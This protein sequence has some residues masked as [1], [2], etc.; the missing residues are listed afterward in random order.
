MRRLLYL[1][2]LLGGLAIGSLYPLSLLADQQAIGNLRADNA[3]AGSKL[4]LSVIILDGSGNPVTSFGGTG[5]T[6]MTD[7][8]AF[9]VGVATITPVGGTYRSTLDTVNDGDAG[10]FA[11]L[12]NRIQMV[13][14]VDSSGVAVS[15]GGG[16]Q[17][18]EDTASANADVGTLA[19]ARR[20][21]TPANTSGADLDYE[22]LQMAAGRL[23]VDASGVTLTVASHAVTN[24][25]TFV[26]Q[27][28]GAALTALQLIDNI[29]NTLGSTTSGQSGVL[30]LGAV[31]TAAP[32]YTN[33]QTNALSLTTAGSLRV[34]VM[35]GGGGGTS[36][37]D[38]ADFTD[39]TTVFTLSGAVAEVASPSTV[40]EGDMGA[41]AMTLNRAL[42]VTLYA[43]DGTALT[44]SQDQT[45]DAA[46]S[47]A[48]TGPMVLTVR[49]DTAA[50]SAGTTGDFATLNT[51]ALGKLWVSGAYAE[52]AAHSSGD[53]GI[54]ILTKRTDSVA[55]SAG[56][57]GD[58]QTLNT[59]ASGR[60]WVNCS[61][62]C[63]G[64]TQY[65]EDAASAGGETLTLA[66]FVRQNTLSSSVGADGDYAYGKVDTNGSL[67]VNP[68]GATQAAATYLSVR[69]TDGSS[70]LTAAADQVEDAASAGG[71]S[72][73]MVLTVR[74]DTA[75]T[76]AG[77]AGDFATLNTDAVGKLWV[78]GAFAEDAAH[79][80][81]DIG[82]YVLGRRIDAPAP[83]S[84]TSGDYESF[85]MNASGALWV[86]QS[87][88]CSSE[89][90]ITDPFSLTARGII[91]AAAASKKNYICAIAVVAGAAE[92]FNVVEGTGT[93]C[94]TS[95]AAIAGSTTAANGL[96][97]AANGGFSAIGSNS[98]VLAGKTANVDTCIMPS[99]SNRLAGFV[100]YVQR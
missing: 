14:M 92:I 81:A 32:T 88:P 60:L 21:A 48:E 56:T 11:M 36:A 96:S 70:F 47:G 66:G 45:E 2:T 5:G 29:P 90:K 57:D 39:G 84:G 94:Q 52:D 9:S 69:L 4:G 55:A 7:D 16:T 80:S 58:Y 20:T 6:S 35:N 1:G 51:D 23:W 100:T 26:S 46:S 41:L 31:T 71:E 98:T 50:S 38:D 72:G 19:M 40:T 62:G 34:D 68:F 33:A 18:A 93:T 30:G 54:A 61:T 95:T 12:A 17:F 42:K 22:V 75:A 77:T 8:A 89:A 15:V 76:S 10:A 83:S 43:T 24:A 78:S 82:L 28:D 64:G 74:R 13:H 73:P 44:P 91:V 49:R 59:D 87:D 3:A 86:S 25:G 37:I 27:I 67:Y 53:L 63:S 85:N 97:F 79:T 65:T 99:G